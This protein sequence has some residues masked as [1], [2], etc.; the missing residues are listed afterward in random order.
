MRR[1]LDSRAGGN[2]GLGGE[3]P[4]RFEH[5][6]SGSGAP[7]RVVPQTSDGVRIINF[8]VMPDCELEYHL[9]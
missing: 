8:A 2:E 3:K 7:R 4:L 6:V 1:G 9:N 5:Y